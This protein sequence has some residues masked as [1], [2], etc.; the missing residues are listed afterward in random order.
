[1]YGQLLAS[2][3]TAILMAC[4][5]CASVKSCKDCPMDSRIIGVSWPMFCS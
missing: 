5:I 2:F 1:M 3:S 4:V